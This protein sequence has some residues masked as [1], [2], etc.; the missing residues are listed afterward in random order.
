MLNYK[1]FII[2]GIISVIFVTAFCIITAVTH[3]DDPEIPGTETTDPVETDTPETVEPPST[4]TEEGA[5]PVVIPDVEPEVETEEEVADVVIDILKEN[6]SHV[7][8]VDPTIEGD[9]VIE[10]GTKEAN[11]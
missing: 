5:P 8:P 9:V 3:I 7:K 10:D 6:E 1:F 4:D 2:I 11:E